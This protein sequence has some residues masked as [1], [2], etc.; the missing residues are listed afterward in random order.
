MTT[1]EME[2]MVKQ[3]FFYCETE[4]IDPKWLYPDGNLNLLEFSAKLIAVWEATGKA[5]NKPSEPL[6]SQPVSEDSL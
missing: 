4:R 3:V 2:D 5:R 1:Q 6:P